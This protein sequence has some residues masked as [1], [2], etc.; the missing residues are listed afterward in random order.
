[1]IIWVTGISGAGKTTLGS[2]IFKTWK[3][4]HRNTVIIDGDV[5]RQILLLE[6]NTSTYTEEARYK[7]A[8][9]YVML[10]KWLEEQSINVVIC[11][12]SNFEVLRE[13]NRKTFMNYFEVYVKIPLEKAIERD[14]KNLYKMAIDGQKKNVVGIDIPFVEPQQPDYV[15]DNST[16]NID[17]SKVAKDIL[18]SAGVDIRG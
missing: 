13:S 12:I 2:E 3:K 15:F 10:C 6:S 17:H 11:T 8:Q 14:V 18:I 1:M 7:I 5:I 9:H 4:Y 16:N